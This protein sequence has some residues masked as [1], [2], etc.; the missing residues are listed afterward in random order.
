MLLGFKE[1][2]FGNLEKLTISNQNAGLTI[3]KLISSF[4]RSWF[5]DFD[6]VKAKVEDKLPFGMNAEICGII[7]RYIR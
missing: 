6:P 5:I 4:F 7:P 3:S 1:E 2:H